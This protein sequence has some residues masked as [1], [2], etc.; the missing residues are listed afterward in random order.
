[1]NRDSY[2]RISSTIEVPNHRTHGT[3]G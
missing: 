1:V 2:Y 3:C